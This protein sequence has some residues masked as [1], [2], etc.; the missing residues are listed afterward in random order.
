MFGSQILEVGIGLILIFLLVGLILTAVR[1]TLEAWM[2]TR[3]RDL[4]RA[5]A[6]LLDDKD[7]TGARLDLYRH[8]LIQALYSGE[9]SPTAF[10]NGQVVARAKS[11]LPSYIPRETFAFAVEDLIRSGTLSGRASEVYAALLRA[12][13]SDPIA[14]RRRLEQWYDAAMDRAAGWYR[15][16]TQKIVLVLGVAVAIVL[17]INAIA[18]G[19][20][21]AVNQDA[22][23]RMA[24][25]ADN[26][27]NEQRA[28][29][30]ARP[31]ADSSA[32]APVA[33]A[34]HEAANAAGA[35]AT[36]AEAAAN[37]AGA[38]NESANGNEASDAAETPVAD[39][40]AAAPAGGSNAVAG[41]SATQ[42]AGAAQ[43]ADAAR[44]LNSL[45]SVAGLPMGWNQF[46]LDRMGAEW[47]SGWAAALLSWLLG[48][49]IV[50]FAAT[51]GAPFW[52]DLLGKFMVIRST[53]KPTEK[54]PDEASKDGG[55]GGAPQTRQEPVA[56]DG[57]GPAKS[58]ST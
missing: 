56:S 23:A 53:V 10:S 44:R 13:G 5:L 52:F 55:T 40:E 3:S 54:S 18:I 4:E 39:N 24:Q 48:W 58:A 49:L 42:P 25:I 20:Y 16:R 27:V 35:N 37:Q 2:K 29:D 9:P 1:E 15:R 12:E 51:L 36:G 6:E 41:N 57:D 38:T 28:A 34:T 17:N 50:G 32:S 19:Q 11:N 14:A 43:G 31:S 46:Q 30:A 7:G 8:P 22:R 47:R 45:I 33:D 26:Y 21:L